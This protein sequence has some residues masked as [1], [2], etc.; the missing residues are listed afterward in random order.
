MQICTCIVFLYN[1]LEILNYRIGNGLMRSS[2]PSSLP[3]ERVKYTSA[4][5]DISSSSRFFD[6]KWCRPTYQ[7]FSSTS[8]SSWQTKPS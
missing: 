3:Q 4:I 2:K 6:S 1:T 8:S 7:R 5:P